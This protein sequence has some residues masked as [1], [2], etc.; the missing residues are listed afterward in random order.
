MKEVGCSAR[1]SFNF[2]YLGSFP[3]RRG[4][5]AGDD[6]LGRS[7]FAK[8]LAHGHHNAVNS[9]LLNLVKNCGI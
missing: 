7:E 5:R 8:V 6:F 3:L 2:V 1:M 9:F 4:G